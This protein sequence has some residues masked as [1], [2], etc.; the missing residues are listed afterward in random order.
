MSFPQHTDRDQHQPNAWV[1]IVGR[2]GAKGGQN[3]LAQPVVETHHQQM[4]DYTTWQ[5]QE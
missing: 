1:S 2:V 4:L 5:K 3:H